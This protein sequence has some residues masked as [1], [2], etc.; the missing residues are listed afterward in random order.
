MMRAAMN[1]AAFR[2]ILG[3]TAFAAGCVSDLATDVDG[4]EGACVFPP[5]GCG[6]SGLLD[7]AVPECPCGIVC[8][9]PA[10]NGH[11]VCYTTCG[12]SRAECDAAFYWD[13]ARLCDEAHDPAAPVHARCIVLAYVYYRAVVVFGSGFFERSQV[14][15]CAC[16]LAGADVGVAD[17]DTSKAQTDA[18]PP[19]VPPYPDADGDGLPDD[20]E[21]LAGLDPADP[22]DAAADP[23]ADGAIN[24]REFI[25]DTDPRVPDAP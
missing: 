16:A 4:T 15:A 24:L 9:T 12:S 22:G 21:C 11:D 6:P 10:C 7:A 5:N 8:F 1:R 20:W 25:D 18:P 19:V 14:Q 17:D 13:M 3:V 2:A 23:D